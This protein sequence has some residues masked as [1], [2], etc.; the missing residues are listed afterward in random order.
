MILSTTTTITTTTTT[1]TA[2]PLSKKI[3]PK[4]KEYADQYTDIIFVK[5]DAEELEVTVMVSHNSNGV[6]K[7]WLWCHRVT[8]MVS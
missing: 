1:T 4:V 3:A 8:V 5:V 2:Y 7:L 6:L